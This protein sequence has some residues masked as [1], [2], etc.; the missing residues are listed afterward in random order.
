MTPG[1]WHRIARTSR[2]VLGDKCMTEVIGWKFEYRNRLESREDCLMAAMALQSMTE[3]I[4]ILIQK[5]SA[6]MTELKDVEHF[7][8]AMKDM[9]VSR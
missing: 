5:V 3:K 4:E 2:S 1:G 7:I 8:E 6:Q 9:P